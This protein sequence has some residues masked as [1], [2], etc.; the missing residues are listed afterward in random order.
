MVARL[1]IYRKTSE[2]MVLRGSV[3][4]AR[5]LDLLGCLH[6]MS[7]AVLLTSGHV[8]KASHSACA[9]CVSSLGLGRPVISSLLGVEAAATLSILP[10][11]LVEV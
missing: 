11:L 10:I 2:T 1:L 8:A 7:I 5:S 3:C 6:T 9:S 4:S